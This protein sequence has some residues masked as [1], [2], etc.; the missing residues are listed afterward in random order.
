MFINC[1]YLVRSKKLVWFNLYENNVNQYDLFWKWTCYSYCIILGVYINPVDVDTMQL[2]EIV[3]C[4]NWSNAIVHHNYMYYMFVL[5]L[6]FFLNS[7]FFLQM[8][9]NCL[10]GYKKNIKIKRLFQQSVF[11]FVKVR[12]LSNLQASIGVYNQNKRV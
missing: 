4:E 1:T 2:R 7:T 10:K 11:M 6:H 8:N 3:L 5:L 12:W 9:V